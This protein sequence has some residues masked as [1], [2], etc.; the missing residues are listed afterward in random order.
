MKKQEEGGEKESDGRAQ[1]HEF[2]ELEEDRMPGR[3][4]F[5]LWT[6]K[7]GEERERKGNNTTT[8]SKERERE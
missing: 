1:Q 5:N 8:T 7:R 2:N 4:R 3:I 6:G